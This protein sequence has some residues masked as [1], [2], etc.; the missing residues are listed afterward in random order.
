M[1][2]CD[3][4]LSLALSRDG[5]KRTLGTLV[6]LERTASA[7]PPCGCLGADVSLSCADLRGFG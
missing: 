1:T 6:P 4:S 7:V 2:S 3:R 5:A